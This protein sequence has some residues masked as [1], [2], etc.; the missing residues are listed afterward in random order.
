[1][2]F[3]VMLLVIVFL[4]PAIAQATA[5]LGFAMFDGLQQL[6]I[7]LWAFGAPMWCVTSLLLCYWF[8]K[9]AGV[10]DANDRKRI[11]QITLGNVFLVASLL[12]VG[13]LVGIFNPSNAPQ[14]VSNMLNGNETNQSINSLQEMEAVLDNLL[15][16]IVYLGIASS[17]L[18]LIAIT[19]DYVVRIRAVYKSN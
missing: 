14:N 18:M 1:M 15:P 11:V 2:S 17:C 4:A 9:R 19:A 13:T 7:P 12:S 10:I 5:I 3:I 6:G 16:M 8:A